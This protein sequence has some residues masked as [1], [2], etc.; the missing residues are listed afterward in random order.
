[1]KGGQNTRRVNVSRLSLQQ[2]IEAAIKRPYSYGEPIRGHRSFN[3]VQD[4]KSKWVHAYNDPDF[5]SKTVGNPILKS[6]KGSTGKR[7]VVDF[8][9]G[10]GLVS[11]VLQDFLNKNGVNASVINLDLSSRNLFA[12]QKSRREKQ[13]KGIPVRADAIQS[14]LPENAVDAA[15]IRYGMHYFPKEGQISLLKE[16]FRAL[17]PAATLVVYHPDHHSTEAPH[18]RAMSVASGIPYEE[19][20]KENYFPTRREFTGMAK[21]AGFRVKSVEE[22]A[23]HWYSPESYA[24]RWGGDSGNE[25]Q[26]ISNAVSEIFQQAAKERAYKKQFRRTKGGTLLKPGHHVVFVLRKP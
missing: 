1:M 25:R 21:S 26:R 17:K 11:N 16:M 15:S 23:R 8:C 19:R 10:E 13:G 3:W 18:V 2:R 4:L 7:V 20:K 24:D 22:V 12:H 5:I 6:L 14:P 9:G